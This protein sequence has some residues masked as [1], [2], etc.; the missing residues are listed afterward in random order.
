MSLIYPIRDVIR[1]IR[2]CKGPICDERVLKEIVTVRELE[3]GEALPKESCNKKLGFHSLF[4]ERLF[5]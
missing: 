4:L 5:Y 2:L 3:E 1:S